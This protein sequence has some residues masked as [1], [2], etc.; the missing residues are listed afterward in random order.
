MV[1]FVDKVGVIVAED[2]GDVDEDIVKLSQAD[3]EDVVDRIEVLVA[4]VF[5][6][7]AA[8]IM[9]I[10]TVET[11]VEST[12]IVLR[13]VAVGGVMSIVLAGC[14]SC[15]VTVESST[16]VAG[17][18]VCAGAVT[19]SVIP[20]VRFIVVSAA[21]TDDVVAEPELPSTAT[22]EYRLSRNAFL[23]RKGKESMRKG[24]VDSRSNCDGRS[25]RILVKR[26]ESGV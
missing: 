13:M 12:V 9:L 6:G 18:N 19:V 24:R 14:V 16:S 22:T 4:G 5:D 1:G 21:W 8:S 23:G 20:I 11:L 26:I 25:K 3:V 15:T 2:D 10:D 7:A 17:I